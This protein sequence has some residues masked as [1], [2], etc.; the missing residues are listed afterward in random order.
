MDS[1]SRINIMNNWI[2]EIAVENEG[3]ELK[4][5]RKEEI[6]RILQLSRCKIK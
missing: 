4:D 2:T 3:E 1:Y 5:I 6:S